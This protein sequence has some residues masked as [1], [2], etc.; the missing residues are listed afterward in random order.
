MRINSLKS[1]AM[2]CGPL[3][4]MIRGRSPVPFQG[5]AVV[6]GEDRGLLPLLQP[7]VAGDASV[8]LVRCPQPSCPAVELAPSHSQPSDQP[9]E[10]QA[11]AS[12]PVVDELND[13][14]PDGLGNP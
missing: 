4:E 12:R 5:V 3:S 11:R 9:P 7:E 10:G 8:M 13:R 2:N 1:L 6:E 14:I